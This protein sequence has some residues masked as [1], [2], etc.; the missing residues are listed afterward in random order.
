MRMTWGGNTIDFFYDANGAPYAMKYNGT[1]YY[2]I[3]NLQGDVMRIVDA[4]GTVTASYDY[5]PYGKVISATG[6]LAS[7]NP[8][9]YR[10]YVYDQETG[11]YYLQS[12][13]YDPVVGR[14]INADSYASTG[15][16]VIGNNMWV[17]CNNCPL[18]HT[19]E[20]GELPQAVTD[21][22]VHDAVLAVIVFKNPNLSMT[23]T[24]VYYN[25]ENI[26]G[27]Y[28]FC[29]LFN[30]VTGEVWELKKD[31]WSRS[32]RT[33]NALAQLA[34][35]TTGKLKYYPK[36]PLK[37]PEETQIDD[38]HFSFTFAGYEYDVSYWSENNG[39]LRYSYNRNA[40]NLRKAIEVVTW[41][42][43]GS[44]FIPVAFAS[45]AFAFALIA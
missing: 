19:D 40:T 39:I 34:R 5:D 35:Y 43:V 15:Q 10:G 27:G 29:D 8:L 44:A 22:L 6:T 37:F 3:T 32:C 28:G 14:F 42:A 7:V 18:A 20:S 26:W 1:V 31:S 24:C 9:R 12:R 2:Y 13:Y 33:S 41:L 38:G 4:S 30:T 23:D 16:G 11:F 45:P 17:Y 36:L 21:K 25:G